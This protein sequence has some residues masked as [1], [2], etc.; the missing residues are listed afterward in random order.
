MKYI[1]PVSAL[2]ISLFV[3]F[4]IWNDNRLIKEDICPANPNLLVCQEIWDLWSER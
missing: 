3:Y 4:S 1:L 2:I